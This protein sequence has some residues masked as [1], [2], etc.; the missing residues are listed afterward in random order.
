MDEWGYERDLKLDLFAT[1][2]WRTGQRRNLIKRVG[3]LS[4]RLNQRRALQRPL[5]RFAPKESGLLD[6]TG[7]GAVT[8]Q[9]L[10]LA[11]GNRGELALKGFGDAGVKGASRL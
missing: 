5:S 7:L 8:R 11:L 9:K 2:R 4:R 10:G 3:E 1:Q 6:Q